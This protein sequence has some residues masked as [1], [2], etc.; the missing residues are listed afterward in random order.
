M[1][2]APVASA[3][4]TPPVIKEASTPSSTIAPAEVKSTD[5]V[6]ALTVLIAVISPEVVDNLITLLLPEV[7]SVAVI[8]PPASTVIVPFVVLSLVNVILSV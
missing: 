7:I 5:P 3:L 8:S 6:P 4:N 1:V 2:I